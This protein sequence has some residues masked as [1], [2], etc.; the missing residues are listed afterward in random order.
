MFMLIRQDSSKATGFSWTPPMGIHPQ[1][2]FLSPLS[3]NNDYL[4]KLRIRLKELE[5]EIEPF[6]CQTVVRF[7]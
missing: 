2:P 6:S 3:A 7:F 5:M 1:K 4:Q